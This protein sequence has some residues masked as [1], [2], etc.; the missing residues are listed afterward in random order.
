[1]PKMSKSQKIRGSNL[2]NGGNGMRVVALTRLNEEDADVLW[3]IPVP[4][5]RVAN[6]FRICI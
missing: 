1:M 3:V 2:L 6:K 4:V 5:T